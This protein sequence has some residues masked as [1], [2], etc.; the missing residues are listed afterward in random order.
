MTRLTETAYAKLNLALHV[1]RRRADG[2]HDLESV[3]A[4]VEDGDELTVEQ[5]DRLSLSING[6]FAEGL[7][8]GGD[9]LV[10][11]AATV[12]QSVFGIKEGARL[13]LQKNLPVASGIGGGSADAAAA[14][15]LLARLWEIDVA[16]PSV[17]EITARLGADV[18]A[19]VA[20]EPVFGTGKGD[21]LVP[22]PNADQGMPVLLVNP[23]V[24]LSTG[25]VFAAWDGVDRGAIDLDAPER[26]RNDLTV[27]ARGL[28]PEIDVILSTLSA[29]PGVRFAAMSGSGATCFALFDSEAECAAAAIPFSDSWTLVTRLR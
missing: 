14:L 6:R 19:C 3:F 5:D 11:Q 23:L 17:M 8:A 16:D 2:Y 12:M 13:S 29:A 15:R 27:P 26:W 9:N 1:R 10:M 25:T 21:E 4:F 28:V 7:S 24:P 22:L 20:S 18:P